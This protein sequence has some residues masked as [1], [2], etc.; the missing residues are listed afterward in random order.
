MRKGGRLSC[1]AIKG[2]HRL[3][4]LLVWI[5]ILLLALCLAAGAVAHWLHRPLALSAALLDLSIAPGQSAR[6]VAEAVVRA[7]VQTTPKFIEALL[8]L[9]GQ[10]KQVKAGSYELERGLTPWA[11]LGKLVRGE[12]SMRMTTLVEGWTFAQWRQNLQKADTLKPETKNLSAQEIMRLLGREGVHPEGRFWPD[13]YAYAK[14]TSDLALMRRALRAMDKQLSLA[15][16]SRG[17]Q[18]PLENV[19]Q[20]LILASIVEKETGKASDRDKVAAVFVNRL[21]MGMR[22]QTDPTV[23]YGMGE[24]YRGNIR[25][26]DL[27]TDTVYNTYTR[28]GLPPTPIAM[29]GK[30]ALQATLH[31]AQTQDLY[32]VARGDGSSQFS[33]SLADHNRAVQRYIFGKP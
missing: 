22:L 19:E 3:K 21:R 9:S 26:S 4:R 13:T 23:I 12:E 15:W 25:K 20:A 2:V 29:P 5:F 11:L 18:L 16:Q 28:A 31:P 33:T 32:F 27:L 10:S 1:S 7:G 6:A 30:A 14:G 8:R 24:A 17:D